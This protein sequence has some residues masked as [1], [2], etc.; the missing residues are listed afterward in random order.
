MTKGNVLRKNM[1][2]FRSLARLVLAEK[3]KHANA[4][5]RAG[6][7]VNLARG[8]AGNKKKKCQCA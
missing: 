3:L 4:E 6:G 8:D 7:T 2:M 1:Q 5:P